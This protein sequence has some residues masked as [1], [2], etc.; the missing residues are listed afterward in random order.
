MDEYFG[1]D[2]DWGPDGD[3]PVGEGNAGDDW[4]TEED[5]AAVDA[6]DRAFRQLTNP[7]IKPHYNECLVC[8][9]VRMVPMLEPVGFAMTR[10]F[11]DGNAPRATNLGARME[12]LGISGD[13]QL[14]QAGVVANPSIWEVP[15]CPD[16]AIP[17]GAPECR[18]VRRGSTQPC[19]LWMWRRYAMTERLGDWLD[20]RY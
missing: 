9:L 20:R 8:F 18:R 13:A 2:D 5:W 7:L 11:R 10:L 12:Q 3:S 6:V 15:R 16:C 4:P 1:P 17:M 19:E 14:L